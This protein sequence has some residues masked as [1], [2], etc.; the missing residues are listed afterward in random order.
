MQ[1]AKIYKNLHVDCT[2]VQKPHLSISRRFTTPT[3]EAAASLPTPPPRSP[4]E[5]IEPALPFAEHL[6]QTASYN[7]AF[8]S[9]STL[10]PAPTP[11][12]LQSPVAVAST[13]RLPLPRPPPSPT[14]PRPQI[15]LDLLIPVGSIRLSQYGLAEESELDF[16]EG[17][18]ALAKGLLQRLALPVEEAAAALDDESVPVV[19]EP[20]PPSPVSG[21]S[22]GEG[23]RKASAS[24]ASPV[25]K[26]KTA[27]ED[28]VAHLIHLQDA[29]VLRATFRVIDSQTVVLR[30]Y[31]VPSDLPQLGDSEYQK[32][33]RARPAVSVVLKVL[34]MID[35]SEEIWEGDL[36]GGEGL[37]LLDGEVSPIV[38][39]LRVPA[40][41]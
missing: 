14:N 12:A 37:R 18:T 34:D 19:E 31:L 21:K 24:P 25:K 26:R 3:P 5:A 32:G 30:V 38:R 41:S 1:L 20:A 17:W 2:N 29:L 8:A 27:S 16:A 15:P 10:T 33:K 13:S 28:L 39:L 7:A 22:K 35:T 11:A 40:P 23:K 9:T 36:S 4:A 6:A